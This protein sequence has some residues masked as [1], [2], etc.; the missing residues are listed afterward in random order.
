MGREIHR[1]VLSQ[2]M[3]SMVIWIN[4][5]Q[6]ALVQ[7]KGCA[8][9][10]VSHADPTEDTIVWSDSAQYCTE[11]WSWTFKEKFPKDMGIGMV[12]NDIYI[13]GEDI[14]KVFENSTGHSNSEVRYFG[15]Y[16][17]NTAPILLTTNQALISI[18]TSS[19]PRKYGFSRFNISLFSH[20]L[21]AI[22]PQVTPSGNTND[23]ESRYRYNCSS[24]SDLP[25]ALRCDQVK[26]CVGGEDEQQCD[27]LQPG[28]GD[29]LPYRDRC[30]KFVFSL[31]F[32]PRSHYM[33]DGTPLMAEDSCMKTYQASL[34][35]IPDKEDKAFAE[36]IMK[37]SVFQTL[38][39]GLRKVKTT[40]RRTRRMYRYLW[41]W[42]GTGGPI[43]Y[44]E[45][46]IQRF[47]TKDNCA[48]FNVTHIPRLQPVPCL[49]GSPYDGW[50]CSKPNSLHQYLMPE[51]NKTL[52]LRP[53]T[54]ILT[55]FPSKQCADHSAVQTF[56]SCPSLT[57][58]TD[59]SSMLE[60]A[61]GNVTRA[62][63]EHSQTGASSSPS[64]TSA[65][66]LSVPAL[67]V[68]QCR[69]G[70]GVHYSLTCDGLH[71]C[72]DGSDELECDQPQNS[73][74]LNTSF[75]CQQTQMIPKSLRCNGLLECLDDS[76][77]EDCSM[78]SLKSASEQIVC[79]QV[80]CIPY[81][82]Q[83]YIESCIELFSFGES[84]LF[85][86]K[87][88]V[89]LD[90]YGMSRLDRL[91]D[92]AVC[93]E[94]HFQCPGG[95]CIPTFLMANGEKDCSHGEDEQVLS[96]NLFC[97]GFYRCRKSWN[98]IH[99]NYVCDGIPHCPLSDDELFC[100]LTCP[101]NC[102]C[103]GFAF[104]CSDVFNVSQHL[105]LRYLDLSGIADPSL[106]GLNDLEYLHFL[107]M[108]SCQMNS[109]LLQNL[110]HLR[111]LDL[112][113]NIF[114]NLTSLRLENL[115]RL[116]YLDISHNPLAQSV[117]SA[118][119]AFLHSASILQLETLVMTNTAVKHLQAGVLGRLQQLASL[120]LRGSPIDHFDIQVFQG[121]DKLRAL[122]TDNSKLCCSLPESSL[123]RCD[124]PMDELS[125]CDD[126]LSSDFF[127]VFL[128]TMSLL[129]ITGNAGVFLYRLIKG[130]N[131]KGRAF[132][133]LVQNLCLADFLMG[134]YLLMIGVADSQYRGIYFTR[135]SLWRHSIACRV[136]G[137]MGL[138]SSEVSAF[139]LT[140]ITV[141]RLLLVCF[142]L[143]KNLH[144]SATSSLVACLSV[145]GTGLVLAA[146]PL[147]PPTA[148]W[149]FYSQTGICLP[150]PITRHSFPGY[151]YTFAVFIVLNFLLFLLVGAGQAVIF[152]VI[153]RSGRMATGG[154]STKRQEQELTIAR[155]LFLVAFSDFCCWFPIGLMG[156]LAA[157]G[158]AIPA[159]VNVWLAV[160]VLPL[161][162]ALNPY[163]YTLNALYDSY[164]ERHHEQKIQRLMQQLHAEIER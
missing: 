89:T 48:I 84:L 20:P 160:F 10:I 47:G 110:R 135:D 51:S 7:G 99:P 114:T 91:S 26:Q 127:R 39:V 25:R 81:Y 67:P 62:K 60:E 129:A 145:W 82:Y 2:L 113:R 55:A 19:R 68:F 41:Q 93:P 73:L 79:S 118:F 14:F 131:P 102:T 32:I 122:R 46:E 95:Y 140:L 1:A 128:W 78:C 87:A 74:F 23:I 97:P 53:A 157:G 123:S 54:K 136:A 162:S 34:G 36:K 164:T 59:I 33:Y 61:S 43:A 126:L 3:L 18:N 147:L 156:L 90:G 29:W 150:L 163:L 49:Y 52:A 15:K 28:C 44:R 56:H 139:L 83:L 121:M 35:H 103:Q 148:H 37:R 138:L 5:I 155:R 70:E 161:N 98:C 80:G 116:Q 105:Q 117:G 76:D 92:V 22:P 130:K 96:M 50:I 63:S 159:Q 119:S 94:T 66:E 143:H 21:K 111:V 134:V 88:Q 65:A 31:V 154:S 115:R 75:I 152:R 158:V 86:D 137:F 100:D 69:Y 13:S 149:Q 24:L 9:L 6:A 144:L 17:A 71:D 4:H 40:S 30:L 45:Q 153:R 106:A 120:D 16:N 133:L 151:A 58:S 12:I 109:I 104:T 141:D 107:N 42:G 64:N 38:V 72:P 112:S 132:P 85:S 77:E 101:A 57:Q 11:K 142:P 8:S 27:Y 125:S 108:S 146:T 124:A